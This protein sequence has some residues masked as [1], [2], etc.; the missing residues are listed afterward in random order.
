MHPVICS[1]GPFTI[2]SWGFMVALAFA[3]G[4]PIALIYAKK[5]GVRQE[6]VLDLFV[7]VVISSIVGARLFYVIGFFHQ[8]KDNLLS[9]FYINQG[10][11]VFIGGIIAAI[12]VMVIYVRAHGLNIWK[13]LDIGTP[14][15]AIGYAIGRIGCLLNGCCYGIVAFGIQQPTQIYSSIAGIIIFLLVTRIYRD[16]KYDGQVFIYGLFFYSIYRFFLEFIRFSPLHYFSLTANQ[17]LCI[18]LFIIS[19]YLLWKKNTTS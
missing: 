1:I 3:V 14:S 2:Y 6:H 18:A 17:F 16:K 19:V 11:L 13:L 9:I 15:G 10:G 8:Y 7:Y 5:E 12:A 4:L